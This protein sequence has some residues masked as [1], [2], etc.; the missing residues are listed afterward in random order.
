M[1]K[2]ILW[3]LF[4]ERILVL[5]VDPIDQDQRQDLRLLNALEKLQFVQ[6]PLGIGGDK[7]IDL[8]GLAL[9]VAQ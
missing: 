8:G 7:D 1:T 5:L 6:P 4:L 3:S 2:S 9:G